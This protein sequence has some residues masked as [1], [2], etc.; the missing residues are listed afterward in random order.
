MYKSL[1]IE[2]LYDMAYE[3]VVNDVD[4]TILPQ[5]LKFTN[6]NMVKYVMVEPEY[7]FDLVMLK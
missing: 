5:D 2:Y 1:C 3:V 7:M 4:V 6:L